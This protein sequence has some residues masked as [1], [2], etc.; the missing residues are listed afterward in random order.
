MIG[1]LEAGG[2]KCVCAMFTEE[3][4]LIERVS[5]P[6]Q[7]PEQSIPAMIA[8]FK[9]YP[10]M[11]ALG[12][13]S[14]GPIGVNESLDNYGYITTTPKAGW[15]NFNFVG[16]FKDEFNVPIAWTTDVNAAAYG[17]MMQG[18]AQGLK[19][20]VY[21]TVGTGIGGGFVVDGNI[22]SGYGHPES[23][24]ILIRRHQ[25]D[26]FK[27]TCPYHNDCLEGMAAGPA[28][29]ARWGKKG[30]ELEASHPAWA[31]EAEY[32]AQA[33]YNYY[34]ILGSEKFIL[35]GGVM[36]QR[37]LFPMI[38]QRFV[39][40]NNGYLEIP[41]IE[42]FIVPPALEDNA[43]ITGCFELAKKLIEAE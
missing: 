12:I 24:H 32:I 25:E 1:A 42:T 4:E 11:R 20:V 23:G 33:L 17:E 30:V 18:A 3:G 40:L 5:I 10:Q 41:A 39:E 26:T 8:F 15:Q 22:V 13:G 35:G 37:Q 29:E 14:F 28:I 9:Q 31:M 27:G 43:G 7:T 2:T 19:N 16:V 38:Q 36:K 34:V 6:T 21:L